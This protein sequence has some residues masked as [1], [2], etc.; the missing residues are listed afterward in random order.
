M[1]KF[2]FERNCYHCK[3]CI[4]TCPTKAIEMQEGAD[5]FEYPHINTEKC[6]D[7]GKCEIVCPHLH[8]QNTV[9]LQERVCYAAILDNPDERKW[10]ASGGIFYALAKECLNK[11]YYIAGCIWDENLVAR[12]VV[13]K[14]LDMVKKMRGSKYVWS[15]TAE[16]YAQIRDLLRQG[17]RVLWG[18]GP[19]QTAAL[20]NYCDGLHEGLYTCS[21][22]CNGNC[23][24]AIFSS[25]IHEKKSDKVKLTNIVFRYHGENGKEEAIAHFFNN[26]TMKV[27][28]KN[29]QSYIRGFFENLFGSET[30]LD[31]NCQYKGDNM[32]G[33]ILIGDFWGYKGNF[34]APHV[35]AAMCT[36]RGKNLLESV[37]A[38][39]RENS[40]YSKIIS[41][42]PYLLMGRKRNKDKKN[43]IAL[44]QTCG[45][46]Y[47]YKKYGTLTRIKKIIYTLKLY[48]LLDKLRSRLK[49]K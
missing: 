3:A 48:P 10:S 25:Y 17:E 23:S 15:D 32:C 18:G 37:P 44:A 28:E 49:D 4:Q 26:G 41:G 14:E 34:Q 5:T 29:E 7:C 40:D 36:K 8:V 21:V 20:L 30:C 9:P 38:L 43:F 1:V 33:D 13:T 47:A 27:Y 22:F 42:N 31:G 39:K 2:D 45:F 6:I 16:I 24:P 19:C 46:D 12:H 35:S 11:G